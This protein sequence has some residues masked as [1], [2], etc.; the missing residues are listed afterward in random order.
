MDQVIY[1]RVYLKKSFGDVFLRIC[2]NGTAFEHG[3]GFIVTQD[4]TKPGSAQ[5]R[6]KAQYDHGASTARLPENKGLFFSW[7]FKEY[8][9]HHLADDMSESYVCLLN[10]WR[11]IRGHNESIRCLGSKPFAL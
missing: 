4:R 8:L 7:S 5:T 10:P 1:V 9:F 3:R 6:I 2:F 11:I